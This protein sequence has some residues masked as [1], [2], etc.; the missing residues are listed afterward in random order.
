[1]NNKFLNGVIAGTIISSIG[2]YASS[3]LSP[4]QKKRIMRRSKKKVM[5]AIDDMNM[6]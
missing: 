1:M 2:V 5:N 4:R 6:F 3:R